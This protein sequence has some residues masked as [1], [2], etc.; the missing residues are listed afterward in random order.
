[1]LL[2]FSAPH[3]PFVPPPAFET[4]IAEEDIDLPPET[5]TLPQDSN[6][7]GTP[8]A[9]P[10]QERLWG[11]VRQHLAETQKPY[12]NVHILEALVTNAAG[13]AVCPLCR[14]T[15]I[16]RVDPTPDWSE[17]LSPAYQCGHCGTRFG[18][19]AAD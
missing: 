19:A 1:L 13:D 17:G 10:A 2:S 9:Q 11:L 18:R 16:R 14:R 12:P 6:L 8:G 5:E 15:K 7:Y 4:L 3:T